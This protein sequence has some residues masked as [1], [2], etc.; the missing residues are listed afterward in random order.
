M[1][2]KKENIKSLLPEQIFE[3]INQNKL[4]TYR[5]NQIIKELYSTKSSSFEEMT[6]ISKT[7]RD[8]LNENFEIQSFKSIKK[9]ISLD[10]SIKYLFELLDGKRIEAVFMPW[11]D[12]DS[13]KL[14]RSTLCIS[15]QVGCALDCK[16][17][18]TGTMGFTR[19]LETH[20]IISQIL[21][22]ERDLNQKITNLVF[23]GMGEPLLNFKNLVQ[24]LKIITHS[25]IKLIS[26]RKITVSTSGVVPKIYQLSE[27]EKPPKL[28]ISLHATT[29]GI[30][31]LIVPINLKSPISK[32]LE[33]AEYYYKKTRLNVTYEYIPFEN[34]NDTYEDAKRLAKIC[35]RVPSRVNLIPYNDISFTEPTGISALLKPSSKERIIE[36]SNEI[37]A[38]GGIVTIRDTFGSD[39]DAACGQ[40]ALSERENV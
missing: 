23:M 16:F 27:L 10:G 17:C 21:H 30:R 35:K 39:I 9:Q 37:R 25:S 32:L 15:S 38:L 3:F 8:I 6:T 28:A 36:F 14:I 29:N 18:A 5:S 12:S 1:I 31:D 26:R 19:N 13:N 34:M 20:E 11:N 40:L 4:E 24:S 33:A 22:I 2:Q 7:L